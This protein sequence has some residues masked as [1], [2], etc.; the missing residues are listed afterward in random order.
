MT[1]TEFQV[2]LT[3]EA[4]REYEEIRTA[5]REC[6]SVRGQRYLTNLL[7]L[8]LEQWRTIQNNCEDGVF[9]SARHLPFDIRGKV[10]EDASGRGKTVLITRFKFVKKEMRE[11]IPV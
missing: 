1:Q 10:Y 6:V 5:P 11:R 3:D 8:P 9:M 4:S 7:R 2:V